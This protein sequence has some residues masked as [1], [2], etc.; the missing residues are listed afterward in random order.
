M[1]PSLH[2]ILRHVS[3]WADCPISDIRLGHEARAHFARGVAVLT[4][5]DLTTHT[6][7]SIAMFLGRSVNVCRENAQTVTEERYKSRTLDERL[8]ELC[9]AIHAEQMVLQRSGVVLPVQRDPHEIA[10]LLASGAY[11]ALAVSRIETEQLAAAFLAAL[12]TRSEMPIEPPKLPLR[13]QPPKPPASLPLD[14]DAIS[15]AAHQA[16]AAWRALES[17]TF[18]GG[19]KHAREAFNR[20]MNALS[21]SFQQDVNA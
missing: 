1:I 18:S 10:V 13:P 20:A 3:D 7:E 15:V 21:I 19:E 16:L 9:V 17:A 4:M 5:R 12:E 11:R 14:A 6:L 8:I 2:A